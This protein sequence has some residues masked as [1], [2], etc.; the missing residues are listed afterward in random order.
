MFDDPI[1]WSSTTS[2]S[3]STSGGCT[4]GIRTV[5]MPMDA[6]TVS[7]MRSRNGR[8]NTT[9]HTSM[10]RSISPTCAS[11]TKSP[12]AAGITR[13]SRSR[14]S[15][16]GAATERQQRSRASRVIAGRA[17]GS[18]VMAAVVGAGADQRIHASP[19]DSW[20]DCRSRVSTWPRSVSSSSVVGC[21]HGRQAP[22]RASQGS[23]RHVERERTGRASSS[24]PRRCQEVL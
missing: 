14:R 9:F 11:S 13:M 20:T 18:A 16:I 3:V 5:T 7:R 21:C 8:R 22:L 1:A 24:D 15:T 23:S 2:S 17:F 12:M 19:R 10:T 4:S 6:R